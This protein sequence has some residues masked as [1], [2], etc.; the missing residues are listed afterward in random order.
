MRQ[1]DDR[2]QPPSGLTVQL[3]LRRHLRARVLECF[4][5]KSVHAEELCVLLFELV[6]VRSQV[7]AQG[8]EIV[9][10]AV[11]VYTMP[12]SRF[13]GRCTICVSVRYATSWQEVPLYF[14]PQ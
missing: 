1:P 6:D 14:T 12:A 10:L 8:V 3:R 7:L 2:P 5:G 9:N 11:Q 13:A 4:G